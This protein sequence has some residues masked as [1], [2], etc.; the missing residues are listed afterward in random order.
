[1]TKVLTVRLKEEELARCDAEARRMGLT[2]T[3]YV[4][5]CL[6]GKIEEEDAAG[7]SSPAFLSRDLIGAFAVGSGSSNRE[8]R[9]ALAKRVRIR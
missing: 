2:R 5:H 9:E 6:F 7:K 4:R 3:E 1:M 8:V